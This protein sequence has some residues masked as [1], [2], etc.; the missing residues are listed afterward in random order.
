[1]M[2]TLPEA[3]KKR[4]KELFKDEYEAFE[5]SYEKERVQ[6]LRF[7]SLKSVEGRKTGWEK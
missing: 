2:I 3:F 6:G 7:N 5:A 4:M 1:M